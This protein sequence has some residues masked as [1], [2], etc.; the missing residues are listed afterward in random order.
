MAATVTI[1]SFDDL[2]LDVLRRRRS[3][4]WR[5]YPPDVLP[6]FVAEMDFP[7]APP[8]RKVLRAAVENDDCGYPFPGE[9][10]AAFA[11]FAARWFGWEV[12]PERVV[13]VP[14]VVVGIAELIEA[15]TEPRAC[16]VVSPPVYGPFFQ[17]VRETRRQLVEA[18]LTRRDGIWELDLDALER[19]FAGDAALYLLCNPQ[20]PTGRAFTRDEL[21]VVAE[22]A[23]RHGVIVLA[24]EIH[25][26]LALAG[27]THVPYLTLG[28]EAAAHGLALASASKAWNVAGLKC[29]VVVSGSDAGARLA[30]KLPPSTRFHAGHL[31]VLASIAAFTEGGPWLDAL[32]A[33]LD[34]NRRRLASLL[35]RELPAVRY[36]MPEA[37]FLAWLDC[38]ELGLGDDP[39]AAFLERGRVALSPGPWFGTGGEG[40]ARL[41]IG[42][43]GALVEEA[44][45]RMA[46]AVAAAG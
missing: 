36:A 31:G 34:L 42:T 41:N 35:E 4:K 9:L 6:A 29:A 43:S 21:A 27:A 20:N 18:P 19:A 7:L 3:A 39:S 22:L 12:D 1:E 16:V 8:I 5:M 40:H 26:P 17:T 45:R 15:L 46:A 13:L 2:S 28:E 37:G 33:H 10:G 30:G 25:A 14:D 23:D 38:R 11:A 44:V 24:D 32:L